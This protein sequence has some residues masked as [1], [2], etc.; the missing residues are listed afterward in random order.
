MLFFYGQAKIANGA[1]GGRDEEEKIKWAEGGE[2]EAN[3]CTTS[4]EMPPTQ[5]RGRGEGF[6]GGGGGAPFYGLIL[7]VSFGYLTKKCHWRFYQRKMNWRRL[8]INERVMLF[9]MLCS[10]CPPPFPLANFHATPPSPLF[11]DRLSSSLIS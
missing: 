2:E 11:L 10:P 7:W 1:E 5:G 3:I 4:E 8:G 6:N 9:F